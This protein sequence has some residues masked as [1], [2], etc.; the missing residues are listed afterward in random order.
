M[1][2]YKKKVEKLVT[3]PKARTRKGFAENMKREKE[4]GKSKKRQAGTAYGEAYIG[5]DDLERKAD[6]HREKEKE[7]RRQIAKLK[8]QKK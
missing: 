1:M 6:R 4:L 8:R 7:I 2:P 3:G 5:I